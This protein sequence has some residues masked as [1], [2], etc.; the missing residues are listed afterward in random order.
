MAKGKLTYWYVTVMLKYTTIFQKQCETV[1]EANRLLKEKKEE[2]KLTPEYY[3][4]KE[5]F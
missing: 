4:T 5:N 1:D 2:Y 3:V